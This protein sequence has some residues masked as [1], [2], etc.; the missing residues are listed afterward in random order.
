MT[1]IE[2]EQNGGSGTG[3]NEHVAAG[4]P[5]AAKSDRRIALGAAASAAL[6]ATKAR[7]RASHRRNIKARNTA[8]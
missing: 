3:G 5:L 2:H 4:K 7:K 6:L 8:G 1:G